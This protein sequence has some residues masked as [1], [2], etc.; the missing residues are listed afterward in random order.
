MIFKLLFLKKSQNCAFFCQIIAIFFVKIAFLA[1]NRPGR[2]TAKQSC[3]LT[4]IAGYGFEPEPHSLIYI[5]IYIY[6]GLPIST[7][8]IESEV[9]LMNEGFSNSN[10]YIRLNLV[11]VERYVA[12]ERASVWD[13]LKKY[14]VTTR[15]NA[16]SSTKFP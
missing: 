11:C 13:D 4:V 8:Q 7:S 1:V 14:K 10:I 3:R 12:P 9:A 6:Y 16:K 2:L 5:Y 15:F